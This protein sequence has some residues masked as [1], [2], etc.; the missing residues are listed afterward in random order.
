MSKYRKIKIK[1]S[2]KPNIKIK[3]PP[4]Q[5]KQPQKKLYRQ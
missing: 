4:W 2:I 5:K 1:S 3:L